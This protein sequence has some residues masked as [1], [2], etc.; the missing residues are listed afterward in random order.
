MKILFVFFI[1]ALIG[2]AFLEFNLEN[3]ILDYEWNEFKTKYNKNYDN[4]IEH[5]VRQKYYME[6]RYNIM[7][8]NSKFHDRNSNAEKP[9][10]TLGLNEYGN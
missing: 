6:N 4:E 2:S 3:E 8:H 1:F 10:F 5:N 7:K 9:S